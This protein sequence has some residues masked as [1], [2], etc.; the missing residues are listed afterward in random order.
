[1]I[2]IHLEVTTRLSE[3]RS[4]YPLQFAHENGINSTGLSI[5]TSY[6]LRHAQQR[7]AD[8]EILQDIELSRDGRSTTYHLIR[9]GEQIQSGIGGYGKGSGRKPI[10]DAALLHKITYKISPQLTE[11]IQELGTRLNL[12]Y[13]TQSSLDRQILTNGLDLLG[14]HP[15]LLETQVPPQSNAK[16]RSTKLSQSEFDRFESLRGE[17]SKN[18]FAVLV[19]CIAIEYYQRVDV[20]Q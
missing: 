8:V 15:E 20:N 4:A 19:F 5:V 6:E 10:G 1:M 3:W 14:E 12:E 9:A 17:I 13:A 7:F 2:R 16:V 11:Q 18:N